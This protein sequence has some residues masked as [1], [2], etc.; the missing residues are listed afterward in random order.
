MRLVKIKKY[1]QLMYCLF[2]SLGFQACT[3]ETEDFEF[4]GD[5]SSATQSALSPGLDIQVKTLKTAW[6]KTTPDI[7][8]LSVT[9]TAANNGQLPT[10]AF[11]VKIYLS[12]DANIN[13]ATDTVLATINVPSLALR[14]SKIIKETIDTDDLPWMQSSFI[15]VVADPSDVIDES[16]ENNNSQSLQVTGV[17]ATLATAKKQLIALAP[18]TITVLGEEY[19]YSFNADGTYDFTFCSDFID[20]GTGTWTLEEIGSQYYLTLL[21][22]DGETCQDY[23]CNDDGSP[24]NILIQ[25]GRLFT[26]YDFWVGYLR[27]ARGACN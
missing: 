15:G 17:P 13:P 11:V 6:A 5:S 19:S 10:G 20:T 4:G 1:S 25:G 22:P 16:V 3:A 18:Q 2:A 24:S 8:K 27:Y 14:K 7:Y 23:L 26:R 9:A 12:P 21:P